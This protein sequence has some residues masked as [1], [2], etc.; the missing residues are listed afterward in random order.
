MCRYGEKSEAK[1]PRPR[2]KKAGRR[3]LRQPEAHGHGDASAVASRDIRL[4][5]RLMRLVVESGLRRRKRLMDK[6]PGVGQE[7][8]GWEREFVL[9]A[10]LNPSLETRKMPV[11]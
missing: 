8:T 3:G 2:P 6:E 7:D 9:Y 4:E 11:I 1:F 10:S 5:M